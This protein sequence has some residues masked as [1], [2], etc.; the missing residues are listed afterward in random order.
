MKK[1][2]YIIGIKKQIYEQH[3]SKEIKNKA[4]SITEKDDIV[5]IEINGDDMRDVICFC[6]ANKIEGA[7]ELM[8]NVFME[9]MMS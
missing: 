8:E 3:L 9:Q 2:K 4:V 5:N 7:T 1:L 6:F